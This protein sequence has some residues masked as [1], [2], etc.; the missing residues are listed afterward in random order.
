MIWLAIASMSGENL[1][2]SLSRAPAASRTSLAERSV[3]SRKP[4]S[5]G[6]IVTCRSRPDRTM[7]ATAIL[8]ASFIASRITLKVSSAMG[9]SG[10]K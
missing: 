2:F 5:M 1:A 3:V 9:P 7:R 6:K 8:P 4:S 10:A